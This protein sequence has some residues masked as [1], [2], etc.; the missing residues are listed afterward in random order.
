MSFFLNAE[1]GYYSLTKPGYI[2][3]VIIIILLLILVS[4]MV[5]KKQNAQKINAKQLTFA[6][7]AIALAFITSYVKYEMPMGGSVTLFSMFFICYIGYLFGIKVGVL[8]A[9][10]YSI[11]QF[12]QTGGSYFLSPFQVCCDYFFAFTALGLAGVFAFK[13]HGLIK[14]YIFACLMRGLFHTIGGYMYWMD[15]MRSEERRVGKEC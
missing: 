6:G 4:F 1:E 15:Y 10:A 3:L 12:M 13:K 9:C 14:G 5:D 11:L 7:I 8:T 2:L